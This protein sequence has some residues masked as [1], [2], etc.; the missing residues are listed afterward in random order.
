MSA[1]TEFLHTLTP[2]EVIADDVVHAL[3]ADVDI[4]YIL[5]VERFNTLDVEFV[6]H[7]NRGLVFY[8]KGVKP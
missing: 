7:A 5:L 4:V 3:S 6:G 2:V 1:E 8:V